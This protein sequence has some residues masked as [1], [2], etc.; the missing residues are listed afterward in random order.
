MGPGGGRGAAP[1]LDALPAPAR[2]QITK[3]FD[4]DGDGKL[5][6]RELA[7]AQAEMARRRE[8]RMA[9]GGFERGS[10]PAMKDA[11][12]DKQDE[13]NVEKVLEEFAPKAEAAAK[14][15]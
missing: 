3:R 2:E 5:N 12:V 14:K 6:E 11:P 15:Q 13:A 9:R 7:A 10:A 8:E 4:Q 1:S